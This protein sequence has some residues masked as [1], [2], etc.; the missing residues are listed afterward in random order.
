MRKDRRVV[1]GTRGSRAARI[2]VLFAVVVAFGAGGTAYA[3][4]LQA[5]SPCS[6]PPLETTAVA[7]TSGGGGGFQD[8]GVQTSSVGLFSININPGPTLA[9]NAAALAAFN[10]AAQQWARYIA[11]PIT[12]NIDA[13]LANMG[14]PTIIGSASVVVLV[15][16]YNVVR[17]AMVADAADEPD[18]GIVASLP[19]FAEFTA[20]LPAGFGLDGGLS[21]AKANL[22]ALGFGGLDSLFGNRDATITF[23]TE[24]SFDFDNRD[25]VDP[26]KIDFE[27]V[28]AH[29]IGH[30][31][32]FI[33]IVDD[34]DFLVAQWVTADVAPRPLD[35]FRFENN[36][37]GG[38]PSNPAEFT[39]FPRYL[40]P[41][42]DA[43]TDQIEAIGDADAELRMSTGRFMGDGRQASHWKDNTLTGILIGI[44]DPTLGYRQVEVVTDA[45]LRALDLIGYEINVLIPEPSPLIMV[46]LVAFGVGIRRRRR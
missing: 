21:A 26:G 44:M 46:G 1:W 2:G 43:I 30:A 31:L 5:G 34:I 8:G 4:M 38:D 28:A 23:N 6:G 39:V 40:A 18:D 25:G 7:M 22:K 17:D 11:D 29:E 13:E 33:S 36:V 35:L 24:F 20:T 16:G 3:V 42:G 10:R 9:G 27:T 15:S 14:S 45:D 41:G 12:V 37:P 19:T 32:G